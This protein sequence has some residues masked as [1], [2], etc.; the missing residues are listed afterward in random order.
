MRSC[1]DFR[2]KAAVVTGGGSGIGNAVTR[3]LLR[4]GASVTVLDRNLDGFEE[5]LSQPLTPDKG[6]ESSDVHAAEKNHVKVQAIRCDLTRDEEVDRAVLSLTET[7]GVPHF[8]VN[9]V[10]LNL[11]KPIFELQD[12]E[13][14]EMFRVNF[15][16]V[17][18]V[19]R[20]IARLMAAERGGKDDKMRKIVNIASTGA[21]QGSANYGGYNSSK[22][23]L[24]NASRVMA[25]EWYAQGVNVNVLCPGPT[26]TPFLAPHYNKNPGLMEAVIK[27]TLAG[28][29]AEPED[30]VGPVLFLLSPASDWI[31]GQAIASD[32]GKGLNG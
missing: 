27:R 24:V 23:A 8:L 6:A 29:I 17:L 14:L 1:F 18:R 5:T 16:G 21:W 12:E 28:R 7:S 15:F 31:V 19:C 10:G 26:W 4:S 22:A 13:L 30:H 20:I 2:G 9:S 32:G 3:A 25:N 11:R